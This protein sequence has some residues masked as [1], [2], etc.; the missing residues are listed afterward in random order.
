[1]KSRVY[2]KYCPESLIADAVDSDYVRELALFIKLKA[3]CSHGWFYGKRTF[4]AKHRIPKSAFSA[5]INTLIR[6]GLIIKKGGQYRLISR[7]EIND[8]FKTKH[9]CTVV[10]NEG[11]NLTA[12]SYLLLHKLKERSAR[13][14]QKVISDLKL[15]ELSKKGAL[16]ALKKRF[17]NTS[18]EKYQ[19]ER[20]DR[21]KYPELLDNVGFTHDYIAANLLVSKTTAY[22][23]A[24]LAEE[25]GMCKTEVLRKPIAKVSYLEFLSLREEFL[26]KFTHVLWSNG[27][28]YYNVCTL[29]KQRNYWA[30][31][32]REDCTMGLGQEIV[33]NNGH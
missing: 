5:Q 13:Q 14:Q 30:N 7:S 2:R 16:A 8:K 9:Q 25:R 19:Q 31:P 33:S 23:I 28:A 11:D 24:K 22:R 17:S 32:A 20:I 29:Y 21:M 6:H 4:A 12:I 1:M 18:Y 27:Y 26:E 10:F 3:I 15:I